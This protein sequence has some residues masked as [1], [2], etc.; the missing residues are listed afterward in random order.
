MHNYLN[1]WIRYVFVILIGLIS[2][3]SLFSQDD[4]DLDHILYSINLDSMVIVAAK[5]GFDVKDF[6]RMVQ[7]DTSFYQ[8]FKNLRT[9]TYSFDNDIHIFDR[10]ENIKA[11]YQSTATQLSEGRCRTMTTSNETITGRYYKR[12][13][14]LNYYTSK[15]YERLFFT[16]GKV[17]ESPNDS[18][19]SPRGMDRHITEL[20]NLIF[21]PGQKA[22]VPLIGS[23]TA[24]FSKRMSKHY[25]FNI[26]SAEMNGKECY[27]FTAQMKSDIIQKSPNMGV[28]KYLSTYFEKGTLQIVKRRYLLSNST[29]AYNFKVEMDV[30]MTNH[31]DRFYPKQIK[32]DGTWKIPTQKREQAKFEIKFD[33]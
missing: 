10:K 33:F 27:V 31:N 1:Q 7:T 20:K 11:S 19:A 6:I 21:Q 9:E 18:N 25:D 23:K 32:Y 2:T 22:G 3:A 8:G 5:T 30:D 26:S 14:K 28:V 13:N 29:F 17:C 16:E 12:K 4:D 15:L 24:I